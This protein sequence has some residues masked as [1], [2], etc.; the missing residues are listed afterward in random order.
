MELPVLTR[1]FFL[2]DSSTSDDFERLQFLLTVFDDI[3]AQDNEGH[4]IF[5]FV[6]K[7]RSEMGSFD[8]Y[9]RDLWYCALNRA[10]IDV[11]D[12]LT[13]HPRIAVYKTSE[14]TFLDYTP[15]HYHALKHLQSWD[16]SNFRSQMDRLLQEIPLDEEESLEMERIRELERMRESEREPE[17]EFLEWETEEASEEDD[18]D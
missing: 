12:H 17:S 15:E 3:Y 10:A 16:E 2:G 7:E 6:D 8:T 4:T 18:E 9:R 14:H 1:H 11:S 5:D 13:R